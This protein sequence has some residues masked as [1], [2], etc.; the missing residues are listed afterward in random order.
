MKEVDMELTRVRMVSLPS[1]L[2][3]FSFRTSKLMI[4]A[5]RKHRKLLLM[6]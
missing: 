5:N 3:L 6:S 1:L 2:T 4:C